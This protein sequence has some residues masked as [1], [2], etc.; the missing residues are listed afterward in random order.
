MSDIALPAIASPRVRWLRRYGLASFGAAIILA[1]VLAAI[2]APWLT[3]YDPNFV[4]VAARLRPPSAG[5]WLGTDAL[6]RDVATRVIYGARV[7]LTV[8]MV[9][10][11]VGALFG[12]LLGAVAA[13]ARG[14][15]EEGLMRADRPGLLLPADH[16]GDGDRRRA[17]NRHDK[18]RHRHAGGVV[19]EI[20]PACPAAW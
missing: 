4:D 20:R 18:H 9:V 16:P 8:G 15:A 1:W 19:A 14:W 11:L 3:P 12:T 7:S 17:G 5:N 6:G 13:Y 10:V 2:F